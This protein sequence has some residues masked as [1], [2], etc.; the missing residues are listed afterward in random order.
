[1]I[2]AYTRSRDATG[3]PT[4]DIILNKS[5]WTI[6]AGV[7]EDKMLDG[8][9]DDSGEPVDPS[10]FWTTEI[11]EVAL[12]REDQMVLRTEYDGILL[13]QRLNYFT[14]YSLDQ[15]NKINDAYGF[16][17]N[18]RQ[19]RLTRI[20]LLP[21]HNDAGIIDITLKLWSED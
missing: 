4:I 19:Y 20:N 2:S 12:G 5:E 16:I 17:V 14:L 11:L 1:M 21:H 10:T 9:V 3:R 7:H 18:G 15:L 13:E 6:P 8:W